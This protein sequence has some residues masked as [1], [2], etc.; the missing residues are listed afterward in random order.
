[1]FN[2][3]WIVP[4]KAVVYENA[5]AGTAYVVESKLKV[6]LEQDYL[7]LEKH[8][9]IKSVQVQTID[10]NQL[11]SQIVREIVIPELT[12]EVNENKNFVQLRKVYNSLILATWYK[13]KIKDSILTQVYADKNKVT[14]VN[15]DDSQ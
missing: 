4:E 15:V 5:K 10:T 6:M 11:G 7:S 13:K 1:T 12:R 9:G 14:G 8:E 3:V 2:K